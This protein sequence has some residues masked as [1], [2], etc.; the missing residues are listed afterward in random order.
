[1]E[2]ECHTPH[3]PHTQTH[4]SVHSSSL[5]CGVRQLSTAP[6]GLLWPHRPCD[7]HCLNMLGAPRLA[8]LMASVMLHCLMCSK[9]CR[10]SMQCPRPARHGCSACGSFNCHFQRAKG[11]P[12]P[13]DGRGVQAWSDTQQNPSDWGEASHGVYLLAFHF[14]P[15]PRRSRARIMLLFWWGALYFFY[16]FWFRGIFCLSRVTLVF[17]NKYS[18]GTDMP[19]IRGPAEKDVDVQTKGFCFLAQEELCCSSSEPLLI[20]HCH[21]CIHLKSCLCFGILDKSTGCAIS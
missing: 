14:P 17:G 19:A 7:L 5:W 4:D 10:G 18:V 16:S 3:P 15:S 9:W 13:A 6:P 21:S 20:P 2:L 1:M 11:A 8:G 12:P